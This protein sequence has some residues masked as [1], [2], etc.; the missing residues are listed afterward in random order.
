ML[1][2]RATKTLS[3]F[4]SSTQ[5]FRSHQVAEFPLVPEEKSHYGWMQGTDLTHN[6]WFLPASDKACFL[7]LITSPGNTHGV[8]FPKQILHSKPTSPHL[9]PPKG[10]NQVVQFV[11]KSV[12]FYLFSMEESVCAKG[13][14]GQSEGNMRA[15]FHSPLPPCGSQESKQIVSLRSQLEL[16]SWPKNNGFVVVF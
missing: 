12:Y 16:P 3:A 13:V 7:Q 2:V 4:P 11:I 9:P 8:C 1:P 15:G 14:G 5:N 10:K 6:Q